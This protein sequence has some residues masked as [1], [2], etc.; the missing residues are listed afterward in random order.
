M[1]ARKTRK[2]CGEK[3]KIELRGRSKR[4]STTLS[5]L[6][7]HFSFIKYRE[8]ATCLVLHTHFS[9]YPFISVALKDTYHD[10]DSFYLQFRE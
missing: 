7:E 4:I 10:A 2:G 8:S 3:K 5:A 9:A 1:D 6:A